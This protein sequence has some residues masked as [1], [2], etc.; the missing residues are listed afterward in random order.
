V[1]IFSGHVQY[2]SGFLAT[3]SH[4]LFTELPQE[5]VPPI[6]YFKMFPEKLFSHQQLASP[7]STTETPQ[8]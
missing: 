7:R 5:M 8:L 3:I 2:A 6:H 1:G 4:R